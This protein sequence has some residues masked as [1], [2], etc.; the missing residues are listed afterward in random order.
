[1]GSVFI[2][3]SVERTIRGIISHNDPGSL[4]GSIVFRTRRNQQHSSNIFRNCPAAC[5]RAGNFPR[6]LRFNFQARRGNA[7]D[8]DFSVLSVRPQ[9]VGRCVPAALLDSVQRQSTSE[10]LRRGIAAL[11]LTRTGWLSQQDPTTQVGPS[12]HRGR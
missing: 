12:F 11:K 10:A 2:R 9:E 1:M 6:N 4:V 3:I 5:G 7:T 8:W